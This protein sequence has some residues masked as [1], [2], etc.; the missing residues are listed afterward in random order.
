MTSEQV[1]SG[2]IECFICH[3]TVKVPW[4]DEDHQRDTDHCPHHNTG[5]CLFVVAWGRFRWNL[6]IN[7]LRPNLDKEP[8]AE[9][10]ERWNDDWMCA[11]CIGAAGRPLQ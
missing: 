10:Y 6:A 5:H 7:V 9:E 4:W 2:I 11:T 3:N 8:T 1:D